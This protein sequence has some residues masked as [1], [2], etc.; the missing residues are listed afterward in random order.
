M[1][2]LGKTF[3][4]ADLRRVVWTAAQAAVAVLVASQVT[5]IKSAKVVA[6]A[7]LVA[8]L[9]AALSAVKNWFLADSS[10]LK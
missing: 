3:T 8:G 10:S 9:A 5:D 4:Q 7:A 6:T 1:T 2:I